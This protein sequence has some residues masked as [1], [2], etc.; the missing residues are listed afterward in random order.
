MFRL[1]SE[2]QSA[3]MIILVIGVGFCITLPA[4]LKFPNVHVSSAVVSKDFS[5]CVSQVFN[6]ASDK[7][8]YILA[9]EDH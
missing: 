7:N 2:K 4:I 8:K 1:R 9:S 6:L 5:S 3:V